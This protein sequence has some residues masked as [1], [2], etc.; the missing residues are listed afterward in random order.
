MALSTVTYQAA[1]PGVNDDTNLGYVVGDLIMNTTTGEFFVCTDNTSTAAVWAELRSSESGTIDQ[2]LTWNVS[3]P[4]GTG[5][6]QDGLRIALADGIIQSIA[7]SLEDRGNN[8]NSI[9][10]LNKH[11]PTKP[12]TTQRNGTAGTTIYTTQANRPTLTGNTPTKTDNAI[13]QATDPDVVS[14]LEGDFFTMD[15][16]STVASN[17]DL[18]VLMIVRYD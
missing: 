15:V 2:V 12:I 13:I 6:G 1:N 16:D 11:I 17:R 4:V 7:I 18:N 3:G 14:F 10:D 8:G 5:T 9:V